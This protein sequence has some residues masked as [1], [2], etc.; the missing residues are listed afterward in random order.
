VTVAR[1]N[2]CKAQGEW[3]TDT[4]VGQI[5]HESRPIKQASVFYSQ[6]V[7]DT[8]QK[9]HVSCKMSSFCGKT[10]VSVQTEITFLLTAYSANTQS[11]NGHHSSLPGFDTRTSKIHVTIPLPELSSYGDFCSHKVE[12]SYVHENCPH[13]ENFV[14]KLDMH[15]FGSAVIIISSLNWLLNARNFRH[16]CRHRF[17]KIIL[18]FNKLQTEKNVIAA[19]TRLS[20]IL[21]APH[22]SS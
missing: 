1:T 17:M 4:F 6:C 8:P 2:T 22:S 7:P 19:F 9:P 13:R 10:I 3:P 20:G 11:M 5:Q 18:L 12:R 21:W 16:A 14:V 15:V